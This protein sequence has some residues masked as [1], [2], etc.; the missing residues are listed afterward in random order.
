VVDSR[1]SE[2]PGASLWR[3]LDLASLRLEPL[4]RVAQRRAEEASGS[5]RD[6]WPP[7]GGMKDNFNATRRSVFLES[8]D[9]VDGTGETLP[10]TGDRE[11]GTL[12]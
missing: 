12:T 5:L 6:N 4:D 2:F 10:E 9:C 3:A 7:A 11:T 8:N 1:A